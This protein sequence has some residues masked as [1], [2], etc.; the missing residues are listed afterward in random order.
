MNR[1][2]KIMLM[3]TLLAIALIA[4]CSYDNK[5]S[6]KPTTTVNQ[7]N[8]VKEISKTEAEIYTALK[9]LD[10]A[11]YRSI[12]GSAT[13]DDVIA[14]YDKIKLLSVKIISGVYNDKIKLFY[15]ESL[16]NLNER[17]NFMEPVDAT[18]YSIAEKN[19]LNNAQIEIYVNNKL[20]R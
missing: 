19:K 3:L 11:F 4:G 5:A 9:K 17:T 13:S 6:K 7:D 14:D 20:V 2:K 8:K 15:D 1:Q 10:G 12:L 18:V 16:L